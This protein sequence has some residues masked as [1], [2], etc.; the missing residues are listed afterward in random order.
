MPEGLES[1]DGQKLSSIN[2]HIPLKVKLSHL[3]R[4][5]RTYIWLL[6]IGVTLSA[7]VLVSNLLEGKTDIRLIFISAVI[8]LGSA[9]CI[10][11]LQQFNPSK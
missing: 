2:F 5:K 11:M 7:N 4:L 10:Y 6:L 1:Q 8:A 9:F 3:Y